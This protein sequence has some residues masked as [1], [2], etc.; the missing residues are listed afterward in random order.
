MEVVYERCCGLNVHKETV[1]ACLIIPGS[2]GAPVKETRT[3]GTMSR[4]LEALGE[5]LAGAGCTAVAME[6]TGVYWK[7]AYN[8]LEGS[9]ELL[10]VNPERV[11]ALARRKTDVRDA[12]WL[13]DLLRHGLLEGSFVP[14]REDRELRQLTR[15]RAALVQERTAE[16][17]RLQKILEGANIKLASVASDIDG[18]SAREML[19]ALVAGSAD[20]TAMAEQAL[21]GR[22]GAH[23]RFMVSQLLAHLDA[24]DEVIGRVGAEIEARMRPFEEAIEQFDTI[25]GV[26]RQTA[27]AI[28]AEIGVD[29]SRFAT[30]GHL[31]SRAGVCPGNDQSAG[32][33]RSGK[34][35]KGS[36][37]LRVA[38]VQAA[39]AA[40]HSNKS[41]LAAQ[42]HRLA[43]R[44][45]KKKTVIA[46]AHSILVIVYHLLSR[47]ESYRD[48]GVSYFDQR[49]KE[50]TQKRLVRRLEALGFQVS[51]TPVALAA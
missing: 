3:F 26:G 48:L 35:G 47:H 22:F 19:E 27:Q 25:P 43:S 21:T 29:M 20:V 49:N 4:D 18:R 30:S 46:V 28:V 37:W 9:F 45:G 39:H 2:G 16:V 8:L 10:L 6:S 42:Y 40:G 5:W 41:Y 17:N 14:S 24:L 32:K 44:M 34:A 23:Q 50:A 15:Y 12:E 7:P 36:K 31:A 11:K 1:V 33:Q 38:L 13:A 51:L